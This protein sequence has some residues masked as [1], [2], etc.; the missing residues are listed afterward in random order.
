MTEPPAPDLGAFLLVGAFGALTGA[1]ELV[2][3]YRDAPL[4]ALWSWSAFG[5]MFINAI[6]AAAALKLIDAFGWTFGFEAGGE[7]FEAVRIL[8]AG[9]SAMALF[10]SA[11]FVIPVEGKDMSIGPAT[12]LQSLLEACDRGVDRTRARRRAKA[13]KRALKNKDYARFGASIPPLSLGL[14]QNP[15]DADQK[16]MSEAVKAI[17]ASGFEDQVKLYL[18]GLAV[19][20]FGGSDVLTGSVDLATEPDPDRQTPG[21]P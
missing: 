1:G 19:L 17:Q 12:L 11:L 20:S 4:N 16:Q 5:Y 3:R 13:V 18:I 9:F 21:Q 10:R 7:D 8:I 14:V 6:A 2:A 15:S